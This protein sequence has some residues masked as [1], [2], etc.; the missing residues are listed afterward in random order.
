MTPA[1][2]AQPDPNGKRHPV[3]ADERARIQGF[4]ATAEPASVLQGRQIPGG[5]TL[6]EMDFYCRHCGD[7]I[8]HADVR[9]K[10]TLH[11]NGVEQLDALGVCRPCRTA[12]WFLLRFRPEGVIESL[13][14]HQW[15]RFDWSG[16]RSGGM[17]RWLG[18]LLHKGGR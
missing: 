1:T 6:D 3:S 8:L 16:G 7:A 2:T 4:L 14:G 17:M 15:R 10:L 5:I 13:V 11:P 12:T 9:L 18:R